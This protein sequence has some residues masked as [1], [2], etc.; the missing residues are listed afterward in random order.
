MRVTKKEFLKD[1]KK[2]FAGS[3]VMA[4]RASWHLMERRMRDARR[5]ETKEQNV[6]IKCNDM[7]EEESWSGWNQVK[8]QVGKI[9]QGECKKPERE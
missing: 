7:A 3:G 4:Q 6:M 8:E 9:N 5:G 1:S 2:E